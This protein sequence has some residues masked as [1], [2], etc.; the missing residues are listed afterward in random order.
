MIIFVLIFKVDNYFYPLKKYLVFGVLWKKAHVYF[1]TSI[2]VLKGKFQKN[3]MKNGKRQ[4][5]VLNL[6]NPKSKL[7]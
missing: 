1:Y 5:D 6:S 4:I 7:K 3:T 2:Q